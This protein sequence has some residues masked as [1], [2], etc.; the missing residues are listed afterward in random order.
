LACGDYLRWIIEWPWRGSA[1]IANPTLFVNDRDFNHLRVKI[2]VMMEDLEE[3][4]Q[5][6]IRET[7]KRYVVG[8]KNPRRR[9]QEEEVVGDGN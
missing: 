2:H 9:Y 8:G 5:R 4:Q 7:G 1:L 6:H 3:L